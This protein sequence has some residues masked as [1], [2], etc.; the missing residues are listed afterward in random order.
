MKIWFTG[1]ACLMKFFSSAVELA[2]ATVL[3]VVLI[4]FMA[5]Y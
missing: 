1:F 3:I 2:I 4:I 5:S